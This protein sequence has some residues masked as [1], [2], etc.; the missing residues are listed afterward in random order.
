MEAITTIKKT[1]TQFHGLERIAQL[2]KVNF[3]AVADT[4]PATSPAA[5]AT[6]SAGL[7]IGIAVARPAHDLADC[8]HDHETK[9]DH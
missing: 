9:S 3:L 4:P 8:A 7:A 2:M 5:P 6:A 1:M